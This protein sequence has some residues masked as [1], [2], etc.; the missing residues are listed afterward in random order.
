MKNKRKEKIIN[1]LNENP[2]S[3]DYIQGYSHGSQKRRTTKRQPLSVPIIC[4]GSQGRSTAGIVGKV[5][6]SSG[7]RKVFSK[8]NKKNT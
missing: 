5:R 2:D 8:K 6:T 1:P 3:T 7:I 4:G